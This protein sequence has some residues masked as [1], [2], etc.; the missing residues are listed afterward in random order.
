LPSQKQRRILSDLF[1]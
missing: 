1:G